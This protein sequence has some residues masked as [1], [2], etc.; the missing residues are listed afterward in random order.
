M[1]FDLRGHSHISAQGAPIRPLP[2]RG[3]GT[4]YFRVLGHPTLPTHPSGGVSIPD[5]FGCIFGFLRKSD[6][7]IPLFSL[8]IAYRVFLLFVL[9]GIL[10]LFLET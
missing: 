5:T 1:I 4:A 3:P 9:F 7:A 6:L 2:G 10:N 8:M